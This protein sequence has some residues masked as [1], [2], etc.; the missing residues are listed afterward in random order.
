MSMAWSF[1]YRSSRWCRVARPARRYSITLC[2]RGASPR[3]HE[4]SIAITISLAKSAVGCLQPFGV[5]S[6]C[7]W[8]SCTKKV[9][10]ARFFE[11]KV[12]DQNG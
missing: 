3:G 5:P 11:A 6:L 7:Q 4:G 8:S 10:D 9:V 2:L 12:A 1:A